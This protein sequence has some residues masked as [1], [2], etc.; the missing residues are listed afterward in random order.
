MRLR[1]VLGLVLIA[2][3]S[4]ADAQTR[5][6]P[7]SAELEAVIEKMRQ[8]WK[9]PGTAIAIV[10]GDE[11]LLVKGF[12]YRD[13]EGKQPVTERTLFRIGSVTKSF[14]AAG[15]AALAT[16]GKLEWN[17]PVREV[18]PDFRL[19]EDDLTARVTPVDL[20]S[21]RTG[22]PRHDA[23]WYYNRDWSREELMSRLRYMQPS[24]DLR[25]GFQYNNFMFLAAGY[26][27]GRVL[28]TNW[29]EAVR[30]LIFEPLSM[31]ATTISLEEMQK[32]RD[33]ASSYLKDK[34]DAIHKAPVDAFGSMAPAGLINSNAQE[35]SRYLTMLMNEGRYQGRQVLAKT[36]VQRMTTAQMPV[37]PADPRYPEL[38]D[39]AY[40]LG[41]SVTSY[42]G[43]RMVHHGGAIDGFRAH[44]VFL[45]E[46]KIGV[47]ALA[48]LGGSN[49]VGAISHE[50]LDR[51]LGLPAAHWSQRYLSDEQT[52]KAAE[53]EAERKGYSPRKR[54]TRPSHALADYPGHYEHP[55]YGTVR[56]VQAGEQLKV[57]YGSL[58]TGLAH[59]HYDSFEFVTE[60]V[61]QSKLRLRFDTDGDGEIASVT[62]PME[63]LVA[64]I[65]FNRVADPLMREPAFLSSLAGKYALGNTVLEVVLRVDGQLLLAQP[66]GQ[67]LELAPMRGTTFRIK[68]RAG[69]SLEF[70]PGA[71]AAINEAVLHMPGSSSVLKRKL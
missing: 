2:V 14:T 23:I 52:A 47:V 44:L 26:L 32:N 46:D 51:V 20:L 40:G 13:L 60:P 5:P 39:T 62:V 30:E 22:L 63:P 8:E 16:Q 55:A 33:H 18:L 9:V 41:L 50:L 66:N 70:K 24:K 35:M 37:G 67:T 12:G 61:S 71:D 43:R 27:T 11:P 42:R 4:Y 64:P 38:G 19:Y 29:E 34:Q 68:D 59:F 48:N 31:T 49:F 65:V 45:P 36:D 17:N 1:Q 28:G 3:A 21:H 57:S 54:G 58:D 53:R 6:P 25:E 69:W 7:G 15:V 10:R 56:I